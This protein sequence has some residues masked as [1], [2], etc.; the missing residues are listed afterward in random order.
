M[1]PVA[2]APVRQPATFSEKSSSVLGLASSVLD[3]LG[4]G[5]TAA[6][7]APKALGLDTDSGSPGAH[8]VDLMGKVKTGVST[9]QAAVGVPKD[10]FDLVTARRIDKSKG[11]ERKQAIAAARSSLLTNVG[12]LATAASLFTVAASPL[13]A[14]GLFLVGHGLKLGVKLGGTATADAKRQ[15]TFARGQAPGALAGGSSGQSGRG[16]AA[17]NGLPALS[18]AGGCAAGVAGMSAVGLAVGRVV[19]QGGGGRS[20]AERLN[21]QVAAL[22]QE[23]SRVEQYLA[24]AQQGR[25]AQGTTA[26]SDAIAGS[27]SNT[28]KRAL[29]ALD[30]A[31]RALSQSRSALAGAVKELRGFSV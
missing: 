6:S 27:A 3:A 8:F 31:N 4:T 21:A 26:V 1:T 25:I 16:G 30:T 2:A 10:I 18:A 24:T 19:A 20:Q 12:S 17:G 15:S 5:I 7:A 28:D 22:A 14:G 11:D 29:A 13:L 23:L 9:A